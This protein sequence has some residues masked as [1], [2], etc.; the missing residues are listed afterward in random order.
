MHV[1]VH[2]RIL[3]V[4][5]NKEKG[6]VKNHVEIFVKWLEREIVF[7]VW[8]NIVI[9]NRQVTIK[10]LHYSIVQLW[11]TTY[12]VQD[13][14]EFRYKLVFL[15]KCEEFRKKSLFLNIHVFLFTMFTF[16]FRN[17][18][19]GSIARKIWSCSYGI[20]SFWFV[21]LRPFKRTTFSLRFVAIIILE[22]LVRF[23]IIRT[24]SGTQT[25]FRI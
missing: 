15:L 8:T 4:V 18:G 5:R 1:K 14:V 22:R 24:D 6:P 2:T 20:P 21:L 23:H 3:I 7:K 9:R 11:N 13:T 19:I 16:S 12:S 17:M 25:A 10:V